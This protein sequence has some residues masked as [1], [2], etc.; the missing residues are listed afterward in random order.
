MRRLAVAL[1]VVLATMLPVVVASAQPTPAATD[2]TPT[3]TATDGATDTPSAA[4]TEFGPVEYER[5]WTWWLG[6]ILTGV[7]G[8]MVMGMA[9][10]YLL[11]VKRSEMTRARK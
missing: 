3:A 4:P 5:P 11:L 8:L 7:A 1:L 2:A 10:A 6:V 9:A